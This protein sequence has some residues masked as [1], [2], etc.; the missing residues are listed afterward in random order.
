MWGGE[1]PQVAGNV[2]NR[3]CLRRAKGMVLQGNVQCGIT[4]TVGIDSP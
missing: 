4:V 1:L 2:V 3:W